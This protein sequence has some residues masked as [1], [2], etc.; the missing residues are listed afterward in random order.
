MTYPIAFHKEVDAE[1]FVRV[2][3]LA[4]CFS[5]GRTVKEAI[6]NAREAILCHIEGIVFDGEDIPL[7]SDIER[8]I[9]HEDYRD[10]FWAVT[11]IDISGISGKARKVTI[12]VPESLL[13]KIDEYAAE[14]NDSRSGLF[15]NAAAEYVA[16][17]RRA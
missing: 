1:Y 4:G 6:L 2:P 3:D 8:Y 17:R 12:S 7:P 9:A 11:S 5:S 14:H 15:L 16:G 13:K 10:S